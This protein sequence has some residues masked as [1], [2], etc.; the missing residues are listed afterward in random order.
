MERLFAGLGKFVRYGLSAAT[1]T[2]FF[3]LRLGG[4][5]AEAPGRVVV[6]KTVPKV[7]P[8]QASL[9]FSSTPT[10]QELFRARLFEEPLVPI[11]GE[12]SAEENTALAAALLGYAKRSG[13]DDFAS[14]TGF[15]E[16]HPRSPW[17]AAL[18]TD[19]GLEYYNTAH[20][21]LA[22]E[23][24]Q[25]A[26]SLGQ[27]A[28]D[29]RGKFLADRAVCELAGLYSRLGR[30]NELAALLKS[31]EKRGFIGGATER[32]NIARDALWSMQNE[33]EVSFRCG[34]LALQS[35]K[36]SLDPQ[37]PVEMEIFKSAS[38]QK[39]FSLPQVAELSKKV[40]LNYQMAFRTVSESVKS[41]SV[42]SLTKSLTHKLAN[43]FP[44]P[45]VVHWKVG[46]YAAIVRQEGDRYLVEDP[47]FAT[48]VWATRQAL[49]AET[50]GY[51]LIPP[52]DLPRGWRSV[53]AQEGQSVWG[54]GDPSLSDP[55]I[56]ALND[57]Q[58]GSCRL[59][60][61]TGMAVSSVHLMLANLQVRDTPVGYTPPVGPPV[62]FTVRYNHRDYLQP[63]SAV[64]SMFGPKWTHDWNEALVAN[65]ATA[66]Y[67]VGGGGAR[68]FTGFDTSTQSYAPNQYD[69][70]LLKRTSTNTYEM[71]W[72]DGS[73]KIFGPDIGALGLALRQVVDSSGNAV[74]LTYDQGRLVALTDAIGQVT[75]ISYQHPTNPN[76]IT[77]VT[78][79][80]G[81]FATF[82]YDRLA[83]PLP[84]PNPECTNFPSFFHTEFLVKITDVLGLQSQFDYMQA[85]TSCSNNTSIT[86]FS[87]IIEIMVTPYGITSFITSGP[88]ETNATRIAETQY[89][90]GS[91]DRVEYSR[92]TNTIPASDPIAS[93]PVGM[94]GLYNRFLYARNTYY[95]SRTANASSQG[96][97]TKAKIYHWLHSADLNVTSGILESTKEPLEGRVWYTYAGSFN[98]I[99]G[100]S[101]QPTH[102]GRV[103]DDGQ[104]QLQTQ[105][106]NQFG[107]LINSVDPLGRAFSFVYATNGID[108]LEVRQTRAVNNE[109]LFRATYNAQHRPLTTVDA[110]GQTNTFTYNA[111]GQRLTATDAKGE[112]TTY[113]YDAD[114]HL[115]AVDGP[116]PGTND[117]V[118]AQFDVFSR[119]RTLTSV[120][121]Y[122]LTFD[123]DVMDRVTRIT[124]PDSTFEQFT[125]NRLD[126]VT[127]RDRAGRQ[128]FFEY[129]N[130]G[131]VKKRTDP[132]DP[133]GRVTRFDWCRC[134]QIK[135]LT[136]PMGRTT[137]WLTDVQ[138]RPTS[139]QYADGSQAT[140]QYENTTSR[141]RLAIDE[142]QQVT[143]FAYNRD[144]TL[145]SIAYGSAIIP[146]P[147]VSLQYDPDYERVVSMTDGTGTTRYSYNPITGTPT[148]GA[149]AL[150]SV[151]GPLLN[152]TVTYSYDELGRPVHRAINGVD[153]AMIFDAAWRLVG[154]TNALGVFA[155]AY[156]GS[157]R[158]LVSKSFPNGQT[159]ERSYGNN[160]QDL[161][162]QRIT[163][164]A[165]ATPISEFLYGRDVPKGRITTWSQQAGTQSPNLLA[166]GYDA[167]NQLLSATV[168]NA[169]N[170]VN[171]FAYAYDP[172]GNR[173]TEQ[174]GASNYTATYNGLNEIRTT[175]APG[176][177][178]TNEW[179]AVD[180]LVAVN[181]GN[182]RTEFT[183]DGLSRMVA[184]RQLLNGSEVSR[185]RFVWCGGRICE[186]RDASGVVTKRFFPQGVKVETG[187]ASGRFFYTRD[188][189]GS[190]RELTDTSGNVRARYAYDPYGRRTK[191]TGDMDTDFSFAGMFQSAEANLSL[192][193]YRAY[194]SGLGRWLSRDPLRG[195]ELSQGPNLYAYVGNEPVN[196]I[197]PEGLCLTTVD[198]TCS[199]QP[200]ACA[201]AGIVAE[202]GA[203]HGEELAAAGE[204]IVVTCEVELPAVAGRL[205][206]VIERLPEARTQWQNYIQT[207]ESD[208]PATDRVLNYGVEFVNRAGQQVYMIP[209][210]ASPEIVYD[211]EIAL[212]EIAVP[213][214]TYFGS[215]A[216]DFRQLLAAIFGF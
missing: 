182:Q 94:T 16:K 149:G 138:G 202:Q 161:M 79:P 22:L 119:I 18:L 199:R 194:D 171:T 169:G 77:K 147:G 184:I 53:D 126:M 154:V 128:T 122:R 162:L 27:K 1:I 91:A 29:A 105:A 173:L 25:E 155:Y 54:K 111:R 118:T 209:Y 193:H 38:T 98:G 28:T 164:T 89:P 99:V 116:L 83:V 196:R 132:L 6:N 81:R 109:L 153:S 185:R 73:K 96:D 3:C 197:D 21:S 56:Y 212:D 143:Q 12:P 87:D 214:A 26:W 110:A 100:S 163:H 115:F 104:T 82:E 103:L 13:P 158:R 112:T 140:Y 62:R 86:L 5:C 187:P 204:A 120:S 90:D 42:N 11:G 30:M 178:R 179:D 80:F 180:R 133:L 65:S 141:L 166:F 78:D 41:E 47:T 207:I 210:P 136:D 32:I 101:D 170:L 75:T 63:A 137:S 2:M 23:A 45:S 37:A 7:E 92:S 211:I 203:E 183:Y 85:G 148:L 40:G 198:C 124:H 10:T 70:T 134:G 190:I 58:T 172:A 113:T 59:P 159:T 156:D 61:A 177:T 8:P 191:L 216:T 36:R 167:A 67:F 135:S 127:F 130:V 145:K 71:V 35:I 107:H 95:W 76:L 165:G 74:T 157:S 213:L 39:G 168:T 68:I 181:V 33:P 57:L 205:Q 19:L 49:E 43:F 9:A 51:F 15:L 60:F 152:D 106:Y 48:T 24:W 34:P 31:V 114:G 4:V 69:Q 14:L 151:D 146:T 189:L 44:V 142:K 129:D 200:K 176:A 144:N 188:H 64:A 160:L 150:A 125:Y 97:Y 208:L 195:A 52:G 102:I 108:L 46:H 206:A 72:P 139:K 66:T 201:A 123:Y 175:T 174:V 20:Y 215:S 17:R 121:G 50:S 186:E 117:T 93:V 88:T 192:T 131:Q 55:N 84:M